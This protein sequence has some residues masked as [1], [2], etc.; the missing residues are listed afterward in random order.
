MLTLNENTYNT[1]IANN[2]VV[3]VDF[4]APWCGPCKSVMP[5]VEAV[6]REYQ[7]AAVFGKVNIDDYSEVALNLGIRSI[8]TVVLFKNG[9]P[10]DRLTGQSITS[11]ALI[12]M[13]N[14]Y[15]E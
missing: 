8:P 12:E 15:T 2:S 6:S 1:S 4:W 13:L 10:V 5:L 11:G 7:G 3:L 14:T 9:T